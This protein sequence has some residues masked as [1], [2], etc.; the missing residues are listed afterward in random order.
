MQEFAKQW[1]DTMPNVR[2]IDYVLP[3][4]ADGWRVVETQVIEERVASDHR[5]VL[6]VLEWKGGKP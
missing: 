6:V 4:K 3:R 2:T 1:E 5:P